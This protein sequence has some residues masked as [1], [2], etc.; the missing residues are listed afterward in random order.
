MKRFVVLLLSIFAIFSCFLSVFAADVSLCDLSSMGVL[1]MKASL[2]ENAPLQDGIIAPGEYQSCNITDEKSGLV[3]VS[4]QGN[5]SSENFQ[6]LNCSQE[7]FLD[8]DDKF[9]YCGIRANVSSA[10]VTP[11][12]R[13]NF[14]KVYPI[15]LSLGL[16]PGDHP[17]ERCSYWSN[18]FYF[19]AENGECVGVSGDRTARSVNQTSEITLRLSN[20]NEMYR[21]KGYVDENGVI[22]NA[23]C[24]G[25]NAGFAIDCW[26]EST[27]IVFETAIPLGDAL[28]S[29][30]SSKRDSVLKQMM[31]KDGVLCGS[32]YSE[33][34]ISSV[35]DRL[36]LG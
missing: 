11:I 26:A 23:D 14:G 31:D 20:M 2:T 10:N 16:T 21:D 18:T 22:W 17:V 24:Y 33:I 19:S 36:I 27:T 6:N 13:E 12:D 3:I 32:F 25:K 7:N 8:F 1:S 29:V 15:T 9:I 5:F 35:G 34:G 28:L 4:S 30:H